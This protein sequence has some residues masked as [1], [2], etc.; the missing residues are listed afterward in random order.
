[1]ANLNVTILDR[2]DTGIEPS[3]DNKLKV[4]PGDNYKHPKLTVQ[5]KHIPATYVKK[6]SK[7]DQIS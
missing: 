5:L 2:D 6:F 3:K 4:E 1:M 7:A